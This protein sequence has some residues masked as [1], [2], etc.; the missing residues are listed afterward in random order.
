MPMIS[1][2]QSLGLVSAAVIL[3]SFSVNAEKVNAQTNDQNYNFSITYDTL[4]KVDP[5]FRPDVGI[6]RATITG[7]SPNAPFGL[8][9]FESNTYGKFDPTTNISKFNADASALGLEGQPILGDRYFGGS[10]ELYGTAD[11]QARFDFVNSIVEGDGTITLTGGTGIFKDAMGE[12][13]F[14]QRDRLTN[15]DLTAPF[16]GQATLNF[17]VK[18]PKQVPEPNTNAGLV[19]M[20]LVALSFALGQYRRQ[21]KSR[22]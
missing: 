4:T 21:L 5:S 17:S 11:D 6:S 8:T 16:R 14:T 3:A 15:T 18:V 1:H 13:T 22:S 20:G 12:I 9:N 10:N 7:E 19:G 2:L